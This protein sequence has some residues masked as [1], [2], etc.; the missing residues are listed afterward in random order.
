MNPKRW[1]GWM[2]M[3]VRSLPW[4]ENQHESLLILLKLAT[5]RMA[6]SNTKPWAE[7]VS[8]G[9]TSELRKFQSSQVLLVRS[10][11]PFTYFVDGPTSHQETEFIC[12]CVPVVSADLKVDVSLALSGLWPSIHHIA[13][14]PKPALTE[15]VGREPPTLRRQTG[16]KNKHENTRVKWSGMSWKNINDESSLFWFI[17]CTSLVVASWRLSIMC[18][19]AWSQWCHP[20]PTHMGWSCSWRFQHPSELVR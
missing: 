6:T 11:S 8:H 20:I 1:V 4:I 7:K 9:F 16:K 2:N 15:D 10:L 17:L 5:K 18:H 19:P 12:L 13:I 14:P 3:S